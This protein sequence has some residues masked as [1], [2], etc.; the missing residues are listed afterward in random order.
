MSSEPTIEQ[1]QAA[2]I[3]V[4]ERRNRQQKRQLQIQNEILI[5]RKSQLELLGIAWNGRGAEERI[6]HLTLDEVRR[7][8][9]MV[10]RIQSKYFNTEYNIIYK[11]LDDMIRQR[12][13]YG[14]KMWREA[15]GQRMEARN[16]ARRWKRLAKKL[17]KEKE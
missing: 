4:L 9:T 15:A 1:R 16:H 2:L 12:I 10:N 17:K 11:D 3:K 14:Q 7:L 8:V 5:E 13:E 6:N